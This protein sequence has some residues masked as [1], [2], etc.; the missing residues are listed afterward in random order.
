MTVG[1][2]EVMTEIREPVLDLA[3][4]ELFGVLSRYVHPA[5]VKS[6]ISVSGTALIV[7]AEEQTETLLGLALADRGWDITTC[8]GPSASR[9][10]M[11]FGGECTLRNDA[12]A[13][14]VFVDT[15]IGSQAG[16]LPKL[17]CAADHSSPYVLVLEGR[18]DGAQKRIG[19][20]VIGSQRGATAIAEAV[21]AA[22]SA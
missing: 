15:S 10:P 12:D 8:D 21:E 9:C 16:V 22:V 4:P 14:V 17:R 7:G 1:Y 19:G 5:S 18:L 2:D 13:A 20:T 3:R 11:M 6:P